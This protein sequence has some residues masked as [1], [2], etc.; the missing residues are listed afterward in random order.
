MVVRIHIDCENKLVH[1][2]FTH[3]QSFFFVCFLKFIDNESWTSHKSLI[4]DQ[5]SIDSINLIEECWKE[6]PQERPSFK[7]L[8]VVFGKQWNY[9]TTE[10]ENIY[11]LCEDSQKN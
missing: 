11:E 5:K 3:A 9:L 1:F 6:N 7:E 4:L 10:S 8:L 2:V